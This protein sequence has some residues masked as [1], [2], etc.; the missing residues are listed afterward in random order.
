MEFD[1]IVGVPA[2]VRDSTQTYGLRFAG[3]KPA[4]KVKLA[5]SRR[6]RRR[7]TTATIR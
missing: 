3:D 2:A 5:T 7:A 4:G 1:S 6:G